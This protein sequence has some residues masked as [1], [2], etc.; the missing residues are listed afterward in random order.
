MLHHAARQRK[1]DGLW[2]WTVERNGVVIA[3]PPCSENCPGHATQEEAE[4]HFYEH[5]L[6]KLRESKQDIKCRCEAPDCGEWTQHTLFSNLYDAVYLC[7]EHRTA[8]MFRQLHPF[9]PG[10]EIWTS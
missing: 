8:E 6:A 1:A 10:R 9:V 5:E 7:D 4:R 2:T 3:W